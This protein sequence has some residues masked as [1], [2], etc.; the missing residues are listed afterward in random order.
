M[1]TVPLSPL[2]SLAAAGA[3]AVFSAGAA[4]IVLYAAAQTHL[5][6]LW[7]R[8][9]PD[10]VETP[11]TA[12]PVITVQLPL[13][14]EAN[15]ARRLLR[16]IAALDWPRDRLQVQVLDDSDDETVGI[17]ADEVAR[18]RAAGLD[19]TQVRRCDRSGFKAGALKAAMGA[20]RGELIAIFDADFLPRPDF[21]RRAIALLGP[22]VGLVQGRWGHLN[23][24]ASAFTRTQAFHLDAHF[25]LEQHARCAGGLLM[26]FNGTAGV[27]RRSCIE[28][29]GGWDTDTLTEDLD[30]A[31]RA[32]LAGW[33][34]RYADSLEAPAE[35]PAEMAAIRAQQHRWMK[36]GAQVAR[37]L[38]PT[39][40][41][42][43]LPLRRKLQGTAHLMG[44]SLFVAVAAICVVNPLL[45]PLSA[46]EPRV[47]TA[48]GVA[49]LGLTTSGLVLMSAYAVVCTHRRGSA[50]RGLAAALT[51]YPL[52]ILFC[53]GLSLH[54]AAAAL[55]GWF[56]ATGEFV[57]TPKIGEGDSLPARYR[58]HRRGW[59][60]VAEL[61]MAGWSAVGAAWA[62]SAGNAAAAGW[63]GAQA[64]GFLAVQR[65]R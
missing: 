40:W 39:L 1:N 63:L 18:L 31:Y 30:L 54:N 44:S 38:L 46:A 61:G 8:R 26:G 53:W 43:P 28:A 25:T 58:L 48:L 34:L 60:Q 2:L 37:K 23:R 13:Y 32:Q 41:R 11:T 3:V 50:A 22:E 27:W 55:E 5:L 4:M 6:W 47:A 16:C 10:D 56:G 65:P 17:V 14:N 15:V 52:L 62:I 24:R 33:Q 7:L 29:A 45:G 36:G 21:L 35:L 20:V 42:G 19:I 9:P 12:L 49:G 59:L 51:G 64:L 57:R